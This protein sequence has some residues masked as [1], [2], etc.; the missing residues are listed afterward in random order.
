MAA[1][2]FLLHLPAGYRAKEIL[3]YHARD[4]EGL[5]ERSEG[6]RIWKALHDRGRS[7]GAGDCRWRKEGAWAR[8]HADKKARPRRHGVSA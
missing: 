3:A 1:Q 6:N 2:V 5:S 8:V 7:G 4:P